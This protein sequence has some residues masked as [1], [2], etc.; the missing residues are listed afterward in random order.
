LSKRQSTIHGLHGYSGLSLVFM[1]LRNVQW[2]FKLFLDYEIGGLFVIF[3]YT[4]VY[5]RQFDD[6]LNRFLLK[7]E[8]TELF[9]KRGEH[10]GGFQVL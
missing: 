4:P 3:F 6:E 5:T 10:F 1:K 8:P 7:T 2:L 9:P